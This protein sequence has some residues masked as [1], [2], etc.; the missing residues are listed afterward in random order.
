M[1]YKGRSPTYYN[2][3]PWAKFFNSILSRCTYKS[4]PYCKKGIKN[5]LTMD[6]VEFLWNRDKAWLLKRPSLDRKDSKGNYTLDNCR[7]IEWWDNVTSFKKP[8]P[9]KQMDLDG[10]VIKV[11]RSISQAVRELNF[12]ERNL[13]A[14]LNKTGIRKQLNGFT[15]EYIIKGDSQ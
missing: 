14:V 9:I 6:D 4:H 12:N 1:S 10:R 13:Y 15:F 8:K 5:Y 2:R 3:K 7:F 11:W